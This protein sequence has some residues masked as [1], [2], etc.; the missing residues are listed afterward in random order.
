MRSNNKTLLIIALYF[1]INRAQEVRSGKFEMYNYGIDN[2]KYYGQKDPPIYDMTKFPPNL[3]TALFYGG[4]DDLGMI[5]I[6]VLF[7]VA[8][9]AD[10]SFIIVADTTDVEALMNQ[11][12]TPPYAHYEPTYAQ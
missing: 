2:M 5:S 12:P 4:Q 10:S 3:P 11:L 7:T 8:A 6:E 1:V 9:L